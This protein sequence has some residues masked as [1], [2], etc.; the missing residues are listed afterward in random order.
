[1]LALL[2]PATPAGA[3]DTA[4]AGET[5][6]F[7]NSTSDQM[8]AVLQANGAV[9]TDYDTFCT[10]LN[11]A[12]MGVDV[13]EYFHPQFDETAAV[14]MLR[15]YDLTTD[16]RGQESTMSLSVV[17]GTDEATGAEALANAFNT[18]LQEVADRLDTFTASVTSE[19]ARLAALYRAPIP[20]VVPDQTEPCE[21]T[22]VGTAGMNDAIMR[23]GGVPQ[24]AGYDAL[25]TALRARGAGLGFAGGSAMNGTTS[26]AWASVSVYDG[27]TGVLGA[28]TAFAIAAT[29]D[30]AEV[31][32]DD[33][34][35]QALGGALAG[36]AAEQDA[37]LGALDLVLASDRNH[38][39]PGT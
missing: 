8:D 7:Q 21:L 23:W 19:N 17:A 36:V 10:R 32:L 25:C 1:M 2:V 14:V 24:F 15:L 3:Q 13:A 31:E 26:Q 20:P 34:L 16:V 37:V 22:Y 9:L 29:E 38:F 11:A 27:A 30:A 28:A 12:N 35:N 18:A 33:D 39:A 5:C 6:S 4:A